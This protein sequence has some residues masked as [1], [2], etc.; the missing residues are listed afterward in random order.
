[1]DKII[2][3]IS[4][5]LEINHHKDISDLLVFSRHNIDKSSRF[6][7]QDHSTLSTFEI[8]S[9]PVQ[10]SKLNDLG[11]EKKREI[12]KAVLSIFPV[13]DNAPEITKIIFKA[14]P[15]LSRETEF[16]QYIDDLELINDISLAI[17]L[18]ERKPPKF[19]IDYK[20]NS[21]SKLLENDYRSEFYRMLGMKYHVGAEEES[22]NGRTDL[23]L[24]STSIN[25][26]IF[27]FKV[28]KRNDYLDTSKQLL[29]YLTETD[30][31]GFVIMGN[32]R[33]RKNITESEYESVIKCKEYIDKS[34][35][36]KQTK[37]GIKYYE[38]DYNFN[39]NVKK[40]YHFILNLK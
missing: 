9:P 6:G 31:S 39:G 18:L 33:K 29:G 11:E 22:K 19:W 35:Q 36:T 37:H 28:W 17:N 23:T 3:S 14:D 12:L 20:K 4:E 40:I 7:S 30:D 8:I 2:K 1:M 34:I 26:K 15:Q 25:R 27:E 16:V 13:Q 32:N 21:K 5:I 10:T 24:K 38:A